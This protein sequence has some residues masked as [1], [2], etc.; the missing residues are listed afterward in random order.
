MD[1]SKMVGAYV[2]KKDAERFYPG[3]TQVISLVRL[4]DECASRTALFPGMVL[5]KQ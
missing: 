3:W 5:Q 4:Y 1:T 2:S